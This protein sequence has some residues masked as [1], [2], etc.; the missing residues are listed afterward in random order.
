MRA[1]WATV[2]CWALDELGVVGVPGDRRIRHLLADD[3]DGALA[4]DGVDPVRFDVGRLLLGRQVDGELD[5]AGGDGPGFPHAVGHPLLIDETGQAPAVGFD[6][7]DS[8]DLPGDRDPDPD[9]DDFVGGE[10]FAADLVDDVPVV[11][12]GRHRAGRDGDDLAGVAE[13]VEIGFDADEVAVT[14][15]HL[16]DGLPVG[17]RAEG[18]VRLVDDRGPVDFGDPVGG[19]ALR[20]RSSSARPRWRSCSSAAQAAGMPRTVVSL[21]GRLA[22][23]WIPPMI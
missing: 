23:G 4:A 22:V 2:I 14:D 12:A 3:G 11:V 10:V 1:I 21:T 9:V 15:R 5:D 6:D 19:V 7:T 16:G 20:L 18:D 8:H 13:R 17:E